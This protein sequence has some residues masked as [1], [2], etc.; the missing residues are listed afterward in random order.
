MSDDYVLI[1]VYGTVDGVKGV[2][3]KQV[4]V[5]PEDVDLVS[6]Y[7]WHL[8]RGYAASV[9]S[10]KYGKRVQIYMHRLIL[11]PGDGILA[12]HI[13]RDKL[14]N[15]RSNLRPATESQNS[16]NRKTRG[17]STQFRG[18]C[19]RKGKF[20]GQIKAGAAGTLY[21]AFRTMPDLA[22]LDYDWA[23]RI[24]HGEFAVLNFPDRTD[25]TPE[26]MDAGWFAREG[27]PRGRHARTKNSTGFRG[28]QPYRGKFRAD[29][30]Y[31]GVGKF[32]GSFPTAEAA[33]RAVDAFELK[34][35]GERAIL[36]FPDGSK[37]AM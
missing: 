18:V 36:N 2:M 37:E 1:P 14:D 33:A 31:G 3:V 35:F 23:A 11:K 6:G 32:L 19:H 9:P 16:C 5:S 29:S 27:V 26:G 13:N 28:V 25:Y 20:Q 22:A 7:R 15:R 34:H 17:R 24:L 12:D 8:T 30:R 10:R 4:K 21:L